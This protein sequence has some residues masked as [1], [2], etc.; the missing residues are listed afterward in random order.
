MA[1]LSDNMRGALLMVASMSAFT[2]NDAV[3]KSLAGVL[4]IFQVLTLRAAAT[5]ALLGLIAWRAG[6]L[7]MRYG[8][9]DR[10]LVILRSLAEVGAAFAFFT[11]LFDMPLANVSAIL[12][13]LPLTVTLAGALFLGEHV[14]WRRLVAILLG[15]VGVMLIIR[16]GPDGFNA[17][18]IYAL[19]AVGFVTVRDLVTR[20]M[21][22]DVPSLSVAF[23]AA[24]GV[25]L[26]AALGSFT[27][28]WRPVPGWGWAAIGG[29]TLFIIAGYLLS[30]MV[31]RVGEIGFVAPFRYTSLV[32]ALL[33]GLAF[34]D[35]WP[36]ALTLLGAALVVATGLFTWLRERSLTRA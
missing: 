30:V 4:P 1:R 29:S 26:F 12:Q 14:G 5:V 23:F 24:L 11:A 8:R 17:Y 32:L 7:H 16:P 10:V 15:L 22:G 13:A 6:A 35:E 21:S 20:R 18:A 33:I 19:V 25:L 34:F 36:D 2:F 28:D 3:I 27:V 31:M 9:Q